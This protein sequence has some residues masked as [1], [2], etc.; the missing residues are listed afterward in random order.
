M[1]LRSIFNLFHILILMLGSQI[2][3]DKDGDL[4]VSMG[5]LMHPNATSHGPSSV[6]SE[7]CLI[8]LG[9][10]WGPE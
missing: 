4:L 2:M 3:L 8:F 7:E 10:L 1:T 9:W 5:N 6:V